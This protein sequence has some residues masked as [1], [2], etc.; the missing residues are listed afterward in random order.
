[1]ERRLQSSGPMRPL[2]TTAI[3]AAIER[4]GP[5]TDAEQR[6]ARR[7]DQQLTGAGHKVSTEPFWCR[8]NWALAHA[9]HAALA[10]PAAA[11]R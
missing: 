1:M 3:L 8:P 10:L 5:G 9:W 2:Q 4:R 7:L 6:A 11:S